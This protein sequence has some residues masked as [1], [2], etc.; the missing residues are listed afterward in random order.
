MHI[1]LYGCKD[2][3]VLINKVH[4][5]EDPCLPILPSSINLLSVITGP[6]L[7]MQALT[8]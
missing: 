3:L 5:L 2:R 4:P 6:R 8:T 1:F 7:L